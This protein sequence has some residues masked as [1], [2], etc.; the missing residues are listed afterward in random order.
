MKKGQSVLII[1]D[2]WGVAPKGEGNVISW[3]RLPNFCKFER[4][5]PSVS[6]RASG[7]SA[8]LK[9][10]ESGNPIAGHLNIGAGRRLR[11]INSRVDFEIKNGLFFDNEAIAEALKKAETK[12]G[13]LH[14]IGLLSEGKINS[15][16]NHLRALLCFASEKG[17]KNKIFIHAILDG[18]DVSDTAG[19]GYIKS[20]EEDLKGMK[21]SSIA[22]V[23]GRYFAMDRNNHWDRIEKAYRAMAER[24]ADYSF[25]SAE[26]AVENFYG[27]NSFDYKMPPV[28]I[29]GGEKM[30]KND[31]LIFFNFR[32][33]YIRELVKAFA[34]PSFDKF[35]TGNILP[36]TVSLTEYEKDLPIVSAY[37]PLLFHNGLSEICAKNGLRQLHIADQERYAC[38][39]DFFNGNMEGKFDGEDDVLVPLERGMIESSSSSV[40]KIAKKVKNAVLHNTHDFI[41]VNFSAVD[42][43]SATGS[44]EDTAKACEAFDKAFGDITESVLAHQGAV[45]LVGSCGRAEEMMDLNT[46]EINKKRTVNPVPFL[47][48]EKDLLGKAGFGGDPIEGDLSL[49]KP[50]GSLSDVAP[51]ALKL[52]NLPIPDEMDGRALI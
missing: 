13:N 52:M 30:T 15:D 32:P 24:K 31:S 25:S 14:L 4:D 10:G 18:V 47:V 21:F 42:L 23:V 48:V 51:T 11:Q 43:A 39:T 9:K 6:L 19:L 5:Y 17:F 26:E 28:V 2:G 34:L 29:A 22:T 50:A 37:P 44:L 45:L 7:E 3:A 16:I 27:Q 1:V 35:A 46:G 12:K 20:L 36:H 40:L 41:V 33:D 38:V 8:G 49:I